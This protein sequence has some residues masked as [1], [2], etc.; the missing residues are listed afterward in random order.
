[1]LVSTLLSEVMSSEGTT[2]PK[3]IIFLRTAQPEMLDFVL[4]QCW[5][6]SGIVEV[7]PWEIS[8][9]GKWAIHINL[10]ALGRR[11]EE[12]YIPIPWWRQDRPTIAE[13]AGVY[14]TTNVTYHEQE[15]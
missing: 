12:A 1:M 10:E 4:Q 15:K 7:V 14:R 3:I 13:A 5:R 11:G 9:D 8:H 6:N 2:V